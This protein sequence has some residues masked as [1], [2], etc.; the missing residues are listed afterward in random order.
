MSSTTTPRPLRRT[1]AGWLVVLIGGALLTL[2]G[3][4]WY[5][6][7]PETALENIAERVALAPDE[8][9]RDSG[10][11][12]AFDVITI[13]SR[14]QAVYGAALGLLAL[15]V[16]WQGYRHGSSWAWAASWVPVAAI[17]TS[18]ISFALS[19]GWQAGV[20]YLGLAIF[21]AVGLLLARSRTTGS[22]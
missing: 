21:L 8:F 14:T 1:T 18:A 12:S 5:V 6:E 16:A 15:L 19:G 7:G 22:A 10:A 4:V 2:Y 13:V 11:A 9:R 17:A 20:L 3:A